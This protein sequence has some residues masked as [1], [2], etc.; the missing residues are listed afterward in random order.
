MAT[1]TDYLLGRSPTRTP[2]SPKPAKIMGLEPSHSLAAGLKRIGGRRGTTRLGR[3]NR[4]ML[5]KA[6]HGRPVIAHRF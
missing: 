6:R 5:G 1:A 3:A 2:I 4:E